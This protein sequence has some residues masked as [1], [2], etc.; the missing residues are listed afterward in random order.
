MNSPNPSSS[1]S[2]HS[3]SSSKNETHS[4]ADAH[5]DF[6][7]TLAVNLQD[8]TPSSFNLQDFPASLET[9]DPISQGDLA[10]NLHHH[11]LTHEPFDVEFQRLRPS[12]ITLSD[13]RKQFDRNLV[14]RAINSLSSRQQIHLDDA[15]IYPVDH[16][17]ITLR[18]SKHYLDF[19]LAV[20]RDIGLDAILPNEDV[21]V[22]PNWVFNLDLGI[23]IRQFRAHYSNL[24]FH[25]TGCMLYIGRQGQEDAWIAF[26]PNEQIFRG[27][28][29]LMSSARKDTTFLKPDR[30][31]QF[32]AFLNKALSDMAY[33][34]IVSHRE[35]P[36]ITTQAAFTRTANIL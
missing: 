19:T 5:S 13:L 4:D 26:V 31:R 32:A 11:N 25:T 34:D 17:D 16:P 29:P 28:H 33:R 10:R 18:C 15:T 14:G 12:T 2:D 9:D 20:S 8:T 1:S 6:D 23:P 21:V 36:D 30:F 3:S 22:E 35:Y 27:D 24:G 7:A